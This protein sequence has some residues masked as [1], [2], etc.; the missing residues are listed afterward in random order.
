MCRHLAYLGPP[1]SLHA[2]LVEP[3]HSL[4]RQSWAPRHQRHGTVNADGYGV[5]WY[6]DGAAG[7]GGPAAPAT[8]AVL[9]R[10]QP[11]WTDASFASLAPAIGA[12]AVLAAVRSATPPSPVEESAT[13]PFAA[14]GDLYS[15]NG[16]VPDLDPGVRLVLLR[17]LSPEAAALVDPRVDSALLVALAAARRSAGAPLGEALAGVVADVAGVVATLRAR[18]PVR[19]NLL[20]TDGRTVAATAYGDTLWT[21][22]VGEALLV[23]SEP[24]DDDPAWSPVPDRSLVCASLDDGL[25]V[26]PLPVPTAPESP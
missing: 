12:G 16:V 1:V 23:A 19:L 10:A 13:A 2:L 9:R 11:I 26:V 5:G 15:H 3:A 24:S 4:Y 6:P 25:T 20:A 21:R 22:A 8:P 14:G 7:A 17:A 18:A